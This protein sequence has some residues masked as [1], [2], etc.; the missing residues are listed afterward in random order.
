[1]SSATKKPNTQAILP[2]E[3][4]GTPYRL[5]RGIRAGSWLFAT[6][7]AAT[8][9]VHGLAPEVLQSGHPFD[10]PSQ[11]HREAQRLFMNVDEVLAAGGSN[12]ANVV[13]VDQY[14]TSAGP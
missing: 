8:D 10:G 3:I 11:A 4:P 14:Y 1:M 2:V 13:R 7:Q 6:G 9:S 12:A 5:A